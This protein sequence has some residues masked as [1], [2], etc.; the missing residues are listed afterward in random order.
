LSDAGR[1]TDLDR[2]PA[3]DT[4]LRARG[5]RLSI[6]WAAL[7]ANV[8]A[9]VWILI[10]SAGFSAMGALI[11]LLSAGL[12]SFQIVF[13]RSLAGF[14]VM[15]PIALRAGRHVWRTRHPKLHLARGAAGIAAMS[16]GFYALAH[17]PLAVAVAITFTKPLFMIVLAVMFLGESVRWRR[18]SATAVG[19]LGVMIMLRPGAGGFEP[20]M[21]VALAQALAIAAA[22]TLVKRMPTSESNLTVLLYFAVISTAGT[23]GPALY[24]WQTPTLEEA[25]IACAMGLLGVGAQAAIVKG[26]RT[27]E[28][29]AAAPFDYSR[30]LFATLFGFLLFSEVPDA[31]TVMGAGVI[32]ASS[33]YIARREARIG[34]AGPDPGPAPD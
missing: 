33:V 20:A 5:L 30:L 31:W 28:A 18:W 15:V 4:G 11:K 19:F 27:G 6:R 24:V 3:P 9:A 17:L 26:Y 34:A 7:P 29:S 14:V 21:L 1:Q 16:C 12:D 2:P 32:V 22:V 8:R 10:A 23:L 25:G 13:F